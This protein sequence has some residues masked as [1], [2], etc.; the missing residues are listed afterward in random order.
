[1]VDFPLRGQRQVMHHTGPLNCF[2]YR[3]Y[4]VYNF[5][6]MVLIFPEHIFTPVHMVL[7]S[8]DRQKTDHMELYLKPLRLR[9]DLFILYFILGPLE[10][11]FVFNYREIYLSFTAFLTSSSRVFFFASTITHTHHMQQISQTHTRHTMPCTICSTAHVSL[12]HSPIHC[13][14]GCCVKDKY[15]PGLAIDL[16][17]VCSVNT[18]SESQHAAQLK[19]GAARVSY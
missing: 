11:P 2:I 5:R 6:I 4:T 19:K 18:V 8:T 14:Q 13:L 15:D 1:M 12:I 17:S 7:K 10:T 9:W 16:W 3:I